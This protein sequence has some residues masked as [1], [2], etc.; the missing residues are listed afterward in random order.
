LAVW[1]PPSPP[2][3]GRLRRWLSSPPH[4]GR[5]YGQI[6]TSGATNDHKALREYLA[7]IPESEPVLDLGSGARRLRRGIVN[8]DVI[9][10]PEVDVIAD[11]HHLPFPDGVFRAVVCQAVIE[12][13]LEPATMIGECRRVL[14]PGGELWLEAPFLYPVH[15]TADYY[16]WTLSGL[17]H[18][19]TSHDLAVVRSGAVMGPASAFGLGWRAFL[20]WRLRQWHWGFRNL[21]A[22]MTS[23]IPSLECDQLM[24][25]PPAIYAQSYLLAVAPGRE[26]SSR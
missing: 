12:H 10:A 5:L 23:W 13:V 7:G 25:D 15:D 11:G 19:V 3:G 8:L 20:D 21:I 17:R 6:T 24:D 18:L 4:P 22:W 26:T 14:R 9:D 2:T 16:R 1:T